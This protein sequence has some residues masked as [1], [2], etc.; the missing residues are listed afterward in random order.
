MRVLWAY[1]TQGSWALEVE[2]L[3]EVTQLGLSIGLAN[4]YTKCC[5]EGSPYLGC[6]LGSSVRNYVNRDAMQPQHM[7]YQQ[8]H[9]LPGGRKHGE[10][11]EVS[12][13]EEKNNNNK[14]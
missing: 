6:K 5:A 1:S 10:G 11:N 3:A 8:V 7:G 4:I 2:G 9:S 12:R 14:K 13:F